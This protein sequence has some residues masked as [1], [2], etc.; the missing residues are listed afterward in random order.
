M[1]GKNMLFERQ[2]SVLSWLCDQVFTTMKLISPQFG[3]VHHWQTCSNLRIRATKPDLALITLPVESGMDASREVTTC[4][5]LDLICPGEHAIFDIRKSLDPLNDVRTSKTELTSSNVSKSSFYI[6]ISVIFPL[7]K[8]LTLAATLTTTLPLSVFAA[9]DADPAYIRLNPFKYTRLSGA[10]AMTFLTGNT[11]RLRKKP[12]DQDSR[13]SFFRDRN[14][15][16]FCSSST[17]VILYWSYANGQSC[18]RPNN[19][20]KFTVFRARSARKIV[21]G[22]LLGMYL[23][24]AEHGREIVYDVIEG[25]ITQF[26]GFVYDAVTVPVEIG[27]SDPLY[28][29]FMT[30]ASAGR[31]EV[32]AEFARK[33]L[34]GNTL[35]LRSEKTQET[36]GTYFAPDGTAVG[37]AITPNTL[38][39]KFPSPAQR[40]SSFD[41]FY[42][43]VDRGKFCIGDYEG[44]YGCSGL[45][46]RVGTATDKRIQV[47]LAISAEDFYEGSLLVKGNP[48]K[49][50]WGTS[51]FK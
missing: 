31:V 25:N 36:K 8:V 10:D 12:E 2:N 7:L 44:D 6:G 33:Y 5:G 20:H 9:T 24:H 27:P 45:R 42:W 35:V 37:F 13:Y 1:H 28:S 51:K 46:I 30:Q 26:P 39:D 17:C 41:Q 16:Y 29:D 18:D 47:Q 34:V 49:F 23:E 14:S 48:F 19:C 15:R 50:T 21:Q 4:S 43:K 40:Q 3:H 11:L 32:T 38:V 22:R